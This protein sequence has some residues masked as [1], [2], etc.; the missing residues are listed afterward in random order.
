MQ[1]IEHQPSAS[2]RRG[3]PRA[4]RGSI[5]TAY[6]NRLWVTRP[7]PG[8]DRFASAWLIRRFI[9]RDATFAFAAAP[10]RYPD[11]V[12]FDMYQGGGF[13]HEG[14]LCTF[15]VLE[16]RFGIR[17]AAVRRIA[18]IVHDID[19]KEDRYKSPHAPTVAQP[20]RRAARVDPRRREA[21]GAGYR[22]VRG[23]VPV[24]SNDETPARRQRTHLLEIYILSTM[25][26]S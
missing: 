14:D 10:D 26:Q 12:P 17:D 8:V 4:V 22:D 24:V 6:R 21:A 16:D 2:K 13:R 7:R 1:S 3:T 20:C 23:A 19:L 25:R 5:A 11:A 18:E 15:E 9:D